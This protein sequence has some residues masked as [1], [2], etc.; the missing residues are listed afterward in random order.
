MVIAVVQMTIGGE[1][2]TGH[3]VAVMIVWVL[4]LAICYGWR[5]R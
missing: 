1:P 2:T 3:V 5:N 4:V